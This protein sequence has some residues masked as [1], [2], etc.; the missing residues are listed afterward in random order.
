M[1]QL[2]EYAKKNRKRIISL[3]ILCGITILLELL[4][5]NFS[6]LKSAFLKPV[7]LMA[8]AEECSDSEGVYRSAVYEIGENVKNVYINMDIEECDYAEAEISITD[9]G[10]K[11]SYDTPAVRIV[12][13]VTSTEYINIYPYD[14]VNTLSFVIRV[15]LGAKAVVKDIT[16]NAHR[17]FDI[18][19]LRMLA[20]LALLCLLSYGWTYATEKISGADD[21]SGDKNNKA[22]IFRSLVLAVTMVLLIIAGRWLSRCNEMIVECPWPHHRQYQELA[23]ALNNGT[24]VLEGL[25]ADPGLKNA[26]NPYDT[27]SLAAEGVPYYMD[28]AYYDGNYYVYFGIIPE[29]LLYYPYYRL[30]GH[31]LTN[32]NAMFVL[33]SLLVIG[34]FVCL[35]QF[36]KRLR[37]RR[38]IYI[39]FPVYIISSIV[40]CLFSNNVYMISRADLY[41]IPVMA[42]T[43][44]TWL[45]IGLWLFAVNSDKKW[46]RIVG[47]IVGSLSMAMVFGCRPQ[48]GLYSFIAIPIFFMPDKDKTDGET[49]AKIAEILSVCIPYALIA[50]LVCWYNYARFGNILEFG[51]GYSLTTNDMNHRGFNLNRLLRGLF[52]FYFQ[53]PV[54]TSD[55]PYIESAIVTSSYMGR[56][57]VEF[58][59][60]GIFA[61]NLICLSVFAPLLGFFKKMD[62]RSRVAYLIMLAASF[63]IAGFDV[64]GAG[65]IYRYTCDM[66]PGVIIAALIIWAYMLGYNRN[67]KIVDS[68]SAKETISVA[69]N[70]TRANLACRLFAVGIIIGL[71]YS[72][73]VLTGPAGAPTLKDDS[74]YTYELIRSYFSF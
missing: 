38:D 53:P 27:I 62:L 36:R 73:M 58:L 21:F 19:P 13:S 65:I 52:S 10:N 48:M 70:T 40:V 32:Y 59:Y 2:R 46:Q 57:I 74:V 54:L 1:I 60:G 63:V 12:P 71:F 35:G 30:T 64:N 25:D 24:V 14:K 16:V 29:L 8:S 23:Y 55:F 37:E 26:E 69:E 42:A 31:D 68:V 66:V 20:V 39:P 15:P 33:Y 72:L 34:V 67:S 47:L 61:T 49:K 44:F 41:N 6:S 5:F 18:K 28:Y 51:A 11:Y 7:N 56:N 45:G 50:A 43:A 9:E 3:G 4:V 17:P 22:D